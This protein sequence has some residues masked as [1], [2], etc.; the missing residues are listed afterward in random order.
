MGRY[1]GTGTNYGGRELDELREPV[2]HG[3]GPSGLSESQAAWNKVSADLRQVG[4][5]VETSMNHNAAAR[6][7]A[8][9]DA[10]T[11]QG[12]SPLASYAQAAQ[13]QAD[14][15]AEATGNQAEYYTAARNGMP[16]HMDRPS[17]WSDALTPWEYFRKKREYDRRV[18]RATDL[19]NGY[20]TNSN[21]NISSMPEFAQPRPTDIG[22]T[23]P[24][25]TQVNPGAPSTTVP[26]QTGGPGAPSSTAPAGSGPGTGLIPGTGPGAGAPTGP[27]GPGYPGG[28]GP[29]TPGIPGVPGT[30]APGGTRP[31]P[32]GSGPRP[33][34]PGVPGGT[35][36]G[37]TRPGGPTPGTRPGLPGVPGGP[38]TGPGT[39]GPG[40]GT[41]PGAPG[42]PGG[43][44]AH[45][46]RGGATPGRGGLPGGGTSRLM[47]GNLGAGMG[48]GA[49]NRTAGRLPG[50]FGSAEHGV[51]RAGGGFGAGSDGHGVTGRGGAAG[52]TLRGGVGAGG[53]S[54]G[55][56]GGRADGDD[57]IEH[58]S[59]DYL[60][61]TEDIF[62]SGELVAPPV[63]GEA[64]PDYYDRG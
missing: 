55:P 62:R 30:P 40:A 29:T 2:V 44:G 22:M 7:G 52:G 34:I 20:Q 1:R 53:S 47:P 3:Q 16:N 36:P 5:Y 4:V 18:D 10:A 43:G 51:G 63:I 8:A 50:G 9:A 56:M 59:P 42:T 26:S 41:R 57:D 24:T 64:L 19:M 31:G 46:G 38:G 23:M 39:G 58:R 60:V 35:G 6:Q 27:G 49:A 21:S 28:G 13:I 45:P 37:G 11:V 61:E 17:F 54:F 33:G 14:F 12:L 32:G 15:A 25:G 48:E